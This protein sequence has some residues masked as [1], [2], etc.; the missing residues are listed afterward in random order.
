M[1]LIN[2]AMSPE[3]AEEDSPSTLATKGAEGPK[4]PYGLQLHLDDDALEKLGL[5]EMPKVGSTLM[6][7]A[8]VAVTGCGSSERQGG[9]EE[10]YCD[11][12]ITD[13]AVG[14]ENEPSKRDP[15]R[16]LYGKE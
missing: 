3:E 14:D 6:L 12:Q 1:K 11:L 9:D 16:A 2:M 7:T 10:S 4:Y 5:T 13:L 15:A 8:K